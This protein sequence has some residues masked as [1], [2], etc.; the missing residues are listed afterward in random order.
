MK[1]VI[2]Q[3]AF[4]PVPPIRGG[5]VEKIWYRMGQEFA[6]LGHEVIHISK[7]HP[8]LADKET[9]NGVYYIRIKG[10]DNPSSILKLKWFDLLYSFHA[11]RY[12]PKDTDAIVTNTFWS[13]V[14]LRGNL[15][16]RVYVSVERLPKGQMR[17]YKHCG[18]LRAN[19][20]PVAEAIKKELQPYIYNKI[21]MI[22]N[23][24]PFKVDS[25]PDMK[26]KQNIILYTGRIHPEKGLDLLI[27]SFEMIETNW[28]L[29]IV[30]PWEINAGGGGK[31]YVEKLKLLIKSNRIE[32]VDPIYDII[33]LEKEYNEASIFVYPSVAEKGETF[34]LA[35]L[36]AMAHGCVPIVSDLSC[37]KD[38]IFDNQNGII[39]NHRST[40]AVQLLN[41]SMRL[42]I[43]SIDLRQI[44]SERAR[45]VNQSHSPIQIATSFINLF[46]KSNS[47]KIN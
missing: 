28:R 1:I 27:S 8:E 35:P 20:T 10:Y 32:F 9:V 39:F 12:I 44:M 29:K 37:F 42:L 45:L 11:I 22:P 13:P 33:K 16:K 25:V 47:H 40:S 26:D 21:V 41:E 18:Y 5:A 38:F 24:L 15:G 19:S 2:L 23:P 17:F 30:G 3:G 34:G 7:S 4:L 43:N 46:E 14:L 31:Q 36:E 6:K